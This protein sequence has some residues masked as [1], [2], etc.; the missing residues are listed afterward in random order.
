VLLNIFR[1]LVHKQ[2][3]L[4]GKGRE[5][6]LM[7]NQTE[8]RFMHCTGECRNVF[9]GTGK[10]KS[11]ADD[12]RLGHSYSNTDFYASLYI[13]DMFALFAL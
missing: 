1:T 9:P 10:F 7:K 6:F 12:P 11:F 5:D 13:T 4:G 8:A 3:Y 2:L